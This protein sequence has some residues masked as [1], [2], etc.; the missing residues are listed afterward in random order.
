[1]L[2][3]ILLLVGVVAVMYIGERAF[4]T[5]TKSSVDKSVTRE[6]EFYKKENAIL[7]KV[8]SQ[9]AAD[10]SGDPALDALRDTEVAKAENNAQVERNKVAQTKYSSMTE[11]KQAGLS[12][13]TCLALRALEEGDVPFYILPENQSVQVT[14]G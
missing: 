5:L 2:Y 3:F 12:E 8:L 4:T 1:M 7:R 6:V 13:S 14:G 11:C 9:I 10:D